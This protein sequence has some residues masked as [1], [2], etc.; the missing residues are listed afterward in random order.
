M[1]A[2]TGVLL[3]SL[4]VVAVAM[5]ATGAFVLGSMEDY[6]RD[7]KRMGPISVTGPYFGWLRIAISK[8]S[9]KAP[10]PMPGLQQH[11]PISSGFLK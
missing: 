4:A 2:T 6:T 3:G 7:L 10:P 9:L 1:L 8:S 11:C 5:E